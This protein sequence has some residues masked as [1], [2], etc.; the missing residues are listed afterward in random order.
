VAGLVELLCVERA[1]DAK[2]ESL[3]DLD[4]VG[5]GED[6]AV[7]NLGLFCTLVCNSISIISEEYGLP[8]RKK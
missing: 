1:A 5:E 3:V 7:V 4:V 6:A 2:G 8:L